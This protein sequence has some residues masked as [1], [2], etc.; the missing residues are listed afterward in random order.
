[1]VK[2]F[3]HEEGVMVVV[4]EVVIN[5]E[6]EVGVSDKTMGMVMVM[7]IT[8]E[9][10]MGMVAMATT[11]VMVMA[12]IMGM[13]GTMVTIIAMAMVLEIED[14]Y[15]CHMILVQTVIRKDTGGKNVHKH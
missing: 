7:V 4:A 2:D 15:L 8:M 5:L 6:G 12:T 13:V 10:T 11:M 3:N 1:M 9:T 14:Q